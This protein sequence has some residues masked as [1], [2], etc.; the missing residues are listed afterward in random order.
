[1]MAKQLKRSQKA[2][3]AAAMQ[4]RAVRRSGGFSSVRP[5]LSAQACEILK[6]R[7]EAVIGTEKLATSAAEQRVVHVPEV[8]DPYEFFSEASD[9]VRYMNLCAFFLNFPFSFFF[10]VG[11]SVLQKNSSVLNPFIIITKKIYIKKKE[12]RLRKIA[13]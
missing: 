2:A 5:E 12:S 6:R 10:W 4:A 1:M 8:G 13:S 3:S 7:I 9:S 11:I